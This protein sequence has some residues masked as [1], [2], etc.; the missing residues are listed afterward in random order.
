MLA[1]IADC[2]VLLAGGMGQGM[3]QALEAAGIRPVL[4][5]EERITEAIRLYI[6]GRLAE[7]PD[8]AH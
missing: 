8:L 3:Y 6:G 2:Q 7:Q 5:T 4:T 1:A